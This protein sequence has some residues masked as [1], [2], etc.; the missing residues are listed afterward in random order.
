MRP[1]SSISNVP[2]RGFANSEKFGTFISRKA[3]CFCKPNLLFRQF[4][5]GMFFPGLKPCSSFRNRIESIIMVCSKKQMRWINTFPIVAL[6]TYAH[7]YWNLTIM[8]SPRQ[9]MCKFIFSSPNRNSGISI[10]SCFAIPFPTRTFSNDM[11]LQSFFGGL[12]SFLCFAFSAGII[13]FQRTMKMILIRISQFFSAFGAQFF[14][15]YHDSN[16]IKLFI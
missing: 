11:I 12:L 5:S 1:I 15:Q 14:P 13:Q 6:M 4:G 2:N 8:N 7:S 10:R 16:C 9:S 3:G